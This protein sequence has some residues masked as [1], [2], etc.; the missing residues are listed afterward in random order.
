[1]Q[2]VL[3]HNSDRHAG[4]FMHGPHW[5]Q[6]AGTQHLP[7]LIDHAAGFRAEACVCMEDDNAFCTGAVRTVRHSTYQALQDLDTE[8][9]ASQLEHLLGEHE[10][11]QLL[12]RR[13]GVLAYLDRL[14]NEQGAC[15][16]LVRA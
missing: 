13:S 7:F 8:A 3:L 11:A 2:D 10:V 1:V 12:D 9:L 5:A 14:A 15:N 16:I 4:H 6:P